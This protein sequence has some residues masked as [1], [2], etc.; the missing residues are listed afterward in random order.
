MTGL[1]ARGKTHISRR[2][3]RYLDFF[4]AQPVKLFDVASYRRRTC[5]ALKDAAWFDNSNAEAVA[6]RDMVNRMA[7]EDMAAFL[8]E[9]HNGVGKLGHKMISR[10]ISIT[11]QIELFTLYSAILDSTNPT[12]ARR[13]RIIERIQ[14]TGAKVLFIEVSCDN[15]EF[16]TEI[17]QTT[18]ATSPDYAGI[19]PIDAAKDYRARIANYKVVDPL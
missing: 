9:H 5:G 16:L 8:E 12:F 6:L 10:N 14:H 11:K 17:Y 2:V 15:E 3:A 1:P 18:A 13:K 7:L 4:H 19:D